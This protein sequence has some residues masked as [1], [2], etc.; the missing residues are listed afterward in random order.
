MSSLREVS[1]ILTDRGRAHIRFIVASSL[2]SEILVVFS[3][4][5]ILV[6]LALLGYLLNFT[7]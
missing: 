2:S 1:V 3:K 4:E 7:E 6:T 5:A